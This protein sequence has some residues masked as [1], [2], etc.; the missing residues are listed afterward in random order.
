MHAHFLPGCA[1]FTEPPPESHPRVP[2]PPR[3]EGGV[4]LPQRVGSG[5]KEIPVLATGLCHCQSWLLGEEGDELLPAFS[6]TWAWALQDGMKTGWPRI[7]GLPSK[8]P[9]WVTG[10]LAFTVRAGGQADGWTSP[11]GGAWPE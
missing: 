1:Y 5:R 11:V 3:T 7:G 9:Q 6:H 8:N 2:S 10:G 4:A